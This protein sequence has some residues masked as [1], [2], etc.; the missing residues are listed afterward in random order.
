[1]NVEKNVNE[2]VLWLK[3]HNGI[4]ADNEDIY[5]LALFIC[6]MKIMSFTEIMILIFSVFLLM[7]YLCIKKKVV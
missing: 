2:S 6:H 1:M 7:I 3:L 4:S 5:I